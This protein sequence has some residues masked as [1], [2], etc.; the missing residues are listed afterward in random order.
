MLLVKGWGINDTEISGPSSL[1]RKGEKRYFYPDYAM[2]YGMM[3]RC[4]CPKFKED[5]PTCA[6]SSCSALWQKRSEFQKWY[7][8]NQHFYA[9]D[10]SKLYLDKDILVPGN[11]EYGPLVCCLVPA[12]MNTLL[13]DGLAKRSN[14]PLWVTKE[15]RSESCLKM[16]RGAFQWFGKKVSCGMYETSEEAHFAALAVKA[17]K[18]QQTV[19]LI[20][21]QELGYNPAVAA[22]MMSRVEMLRQFYDQKIIV[23]TLI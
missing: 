20:Y 13:N 17:D 7:F 14:L 1:R 3:V 11:K 22:A 6:D 16:F 23:T 19:E 15:G 12:Y 8:S 2:W 10:G 18:I 21:A 4:L 9:N 5:N